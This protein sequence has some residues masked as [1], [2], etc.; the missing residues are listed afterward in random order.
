VKIYILILFTLFVS[1]CSKESTISDGQVFRVGVPYLPKKIDPRHNYI[2]SF[3]YINTH[4]F[5]PLFSMSI[6]GQIES[7]LLDMSKTR[8]T[9]S[10][11]RNF[12]LCL[13]P[14]IHFTD[15]SPITVYDLEES[16]KE[17]HAVRFNLQK[18]VAI[19]LTSPLCLHVE[20]ENKDAQYF[21]KL[22]TIQSTILKKGTSNKELPI[23][24]GP[25]LLISN[26]PEKV[27]LKSF[28]NYVEGDFKKIEFI[29]VKEQNDTFKY[30]ITD[31]NHNYLFNVPDAFK[32]ESFGIKRMLLKTYS[33][34]IDYK[35]ESSRKV[36]R[37]CLKE[38]GIFHYFT[39]NYSLA[40]NDGLLPKGL[41]GSD[42]PEKLTKDPLCQ[43]SELKNVRLICTGD[44]MCNS[45]K[46]FLAQES[47]HLPF[48]ITFEQVSSEKY[49]QLV[50][51][52]EEIVTLMGNDCIDQDSSGFF[53][54]LYGKERYSNIE[55]PKLKESIIKAA[56]SDNDEE[57]AKYY[58]LAN[59]FVI[60]SGLMLPLGQ[61][62]V[63]QYY[64]KSISNLRILNSTMGYPQINLFKVG[65]E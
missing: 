27:V 16:L 54:G 31:N 19:K 3:H 11:Y 21:H 37:S 34:L 32:K 53:E 46:N 18:I 12:E 47:K 15:N 45:F 38:R 56:L 51:S 64:P 36:I 8:A 61:V 25:Y 22:T 49:V 14:N 43:K 55:I 7:R 39:E 2:N 6:T 10:E 4:L 63:E 13:N 62:V 42:R 9:D 29:I 24:L 59:E 40:E 41:L 17:T 28:E 35:N 44:K 52:S 60:N 48:K 20:L 23:G 57:K 65:H 33:I 5:F 58:R 30:Q 1:A 26:T 50:Q